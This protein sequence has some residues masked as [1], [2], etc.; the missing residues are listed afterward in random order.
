MTVPYAVRKALYTAFTGSALETSLTGGL[1]D[2]EAPQGTATPYG[3]WTFTSLA[4]R[5][6]ER[7]RVQVQLYADGPSATT[8]DTL[9]K[10][11]VELFHDLTL[12]ATDLNG[13]LGLEY[14]GM[15]VRERAEHGTWWA[16]LEFNVWVERDP[17]LG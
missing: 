17:Y 12:V 8:L 5:W 7:W 3:A 6:W 2:G 9:V 11:A 16:V 13:N 10:L 4:D 15:P 1:W 14:G